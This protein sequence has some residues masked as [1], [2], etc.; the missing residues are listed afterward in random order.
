[1]WRF[2]LLMV[3]LWLA[4]LTVASSPTLGD[5]VLD[6]DGDGCS[7]AKERGPSLSLGGQRDPNYFW[8]FFDTPSRDAVMSVSDIARVV[9]RFGAVRDSV[10]SKEESL[11][12]ALT[13][14]P[15]AP[16][17]HA[18]FDR[19][20]ATEALVGPPDGTISIGDVSRSVA[21]FGH[22]CIGPEVSGSWTEG[23]AMPTPRTEVT[24]AA[25]DGEIYV[26]GGFVASGQ[27]T[28]IVEAY[29]TEADTWSVKEPLPVAL[30]HA[31]AAAAGGK[32]Y[33]LGGYISLAQGVIS[34]ATYEY[35]PLAGTWTSR[36]SMPLPRAGAAT[37]AVDGT[38]Y[39]L[40]GVGPDETVPLAYHAASDTWSQLAPMSAPREHLTAVAMG[41]KIY[42]AGGRQNVTQNVDTLEVYDTASDSWQTLEPLP[43]ARGGLGAGALAGRMHVVG[44][45][46]LAPGGATYPQHEIYDPAVDAWQPGPPLPTP[47][48]GLTAQVL[49]GKLYVIG[50]GPA[51]RLS[52][53]GAVEIFQIKP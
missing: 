27:H 52:V 6:N 22:S 4:A 48:H 10:P 44:G 47:R 9:A 33:V 13:V 45:E 39:V 1:M 30:D 18:A 5:G 7:D 3:L 35:D 2:T 8:D 36:A 16:A 41:G 51:P 50:G 15:P 17:Y 14:P 29:D 21:Q 53:S 23:A 20:P 19:S 34:A 26:V 12:E 37:V 32:I 31:G 40:G 43:T 24:S 49:D 42:V 25:L 46:D 11:A 28:G 38:I